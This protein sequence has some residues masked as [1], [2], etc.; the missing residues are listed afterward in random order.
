MR[1]LFE[2]SRITLAVQS[3]SSIDISFKYISTLTIYS[4]MA[5][6]ELSSARILS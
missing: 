6:S 2:A 5:F 4:N 3:P 1:K